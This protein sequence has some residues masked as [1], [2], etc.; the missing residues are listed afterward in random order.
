VVARVVVFALG[1]RAAP[2]N[3]FGRS[4]VPE[5]TDVHAPVVEFRTALRTNF[6]NSCHLPN[7]R[8]TTVIGGRRVVRARGQRRRPCPYLVLWV[9]QADWLAHP[10]QRL[11]KI[12]LEAG[13]ARPPAHQIDNPA[14]WAP[15]A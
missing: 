7:V 6:M 10:P 15:H 4:W 3:Q 11:L 2:R 13:H 12:R 1:V 8:G 14:T 5:G 9:E